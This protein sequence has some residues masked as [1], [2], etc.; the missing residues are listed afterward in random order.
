VIKN[1][2]FLFLFILIS[3]ISSCKACPIKK[4]LAKEDRYQE[5]VIYAKEHL[6]HEG[7]LVQNSDGYAYLKVNDNYIHDLFPRLKAEPGFQ[8]PP[9][10]RRKDAPGAH[11]SVAYEDE[12]V[13]FVE[14]GKT[15]QFTI[16]NIRA[17]EVN[18]NTSYIILDIY[19]P[20]L[21][22]LRK[23]YGL[24]PKLKNHQFHITIAKKIER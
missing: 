13:K 22:E 8:K 20:E 17:I 12:K 1:K 14:A 9:Y 6:A 19:A 7:V 4:D 10:F 11:V 21:E 3:L 23:R 2:K 16:T 18:K 5:A 24:S 15:Y